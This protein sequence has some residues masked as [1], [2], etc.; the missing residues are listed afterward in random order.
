ML[1]SGGVQWAELLKGRNI[2]QWLADVHVA[3]EFVPVG[4]Q[5]HFM[6]IRHLGHGGLPAG[7]TVTQ[8][9]LVAHR[10]FGVHMER[11]VGIKL[12]KWRFEGF[13]TPGTKL[14]HAG[15]PEETAPQVLDDESGVALYV[16]SKWVAEKQVQHKNNPT[17]F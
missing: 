8:E 5:L 9:Q 17:Y 16:P 3:L 11:D 12:D 6:D 2:R 4:V 7:V 15:S 1:R 14:H 13:F 10:A